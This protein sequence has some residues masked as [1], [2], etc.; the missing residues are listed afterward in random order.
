MTDR[1]DRNES[2]APSAEQ[3]RRDGNLYLSS[4]AALGAVGAASAA[5]VGATCPLCVV[6]APGLVGYG[7]Y[8]R[9][10]AARSEAERGPDAAEGET[11]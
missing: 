11:G 1:S 8:K 3:E 4:G 7:L 9:W 5:L 2:E 10:C 6:A